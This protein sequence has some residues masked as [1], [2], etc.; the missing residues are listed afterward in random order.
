VR[1]AYLAGPMTPRGKRADTGNAAIEYLLNIRDLVHAAVVLV[2]KGFAPYCP[3]LDLQYFLSLA[4]GKVIDEATIKAVSIAFLDIADCIV[5]L[6][7][8]E[9]SPG[10]E[11]EYARACELG[12]LTYF[13][14][15]QV[16][17]AR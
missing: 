2:E 8:W 9:T 11:A 12:M 16:P 17:D 13:G 6:P 10:S 3:A 4:P 5:L 7:R 14:V 1:I 15:E